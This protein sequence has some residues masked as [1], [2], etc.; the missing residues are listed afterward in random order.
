MFPNVQIRSIKTKRTKNSKYIRP[1]LF[2]QEYL[3]N[4]YAVVSTEVISKSL[5]KLHFSYNAS[6]I[7]TMTFRNTNEQGLLLISIFTA[8]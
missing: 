7:L 2:V 3:A 4:L 5:E 1:K 6:Q 8:L